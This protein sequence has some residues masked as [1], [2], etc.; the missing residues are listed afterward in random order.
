MKFSVESVTIKS[1]TGSNEE[2][3]SVTMSKMLET[4]IKVDPIKIKIR[5]TKIINLGISLSLSLSLSL[6]LSLSLSLSLFLSLTHIHTHAQAQVCKHNYNNSVYQLFSNVSSI[7]T[8]SNYNHTICVC[9]HSEKE[10]ASS[11]P[12]YKT[13]KHNL[14]KIVKN[15]NVQTTLLNVVLQAQKIQVHTLL[16]LKMYLLHLYETG[17]TLPK[18]DCGFIRNIMRIICYKSNN[19]LVTTTTTTTTTT[20]TS[21]TSTSTTTSTTG[22][23]GGGG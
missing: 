3:D 7:L 2:V 23:S 9:L 4:D 15:D 21:S 1:E 14:S 13:V 5:K 10:E 12:Y 6:F 20:I 17:V 16:F 22:G 11:K 19:E 18:I 8:L